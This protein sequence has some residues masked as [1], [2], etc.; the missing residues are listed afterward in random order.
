MLRSSGH[1]R[2]NQLEKLDQVEVGQKIRNPKQN[3]IPLH[4]CDADL[5]EHAKQLTLVSVTVEGPLLQ[6]I[7][8]HFSLHSKNIY[9]SS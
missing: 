9:L 5:A 6:L 3:V 2:P 7:A 1:F 4:E 8:L